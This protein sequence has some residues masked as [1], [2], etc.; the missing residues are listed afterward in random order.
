[1]SITALLSLGE[2]AIAAGAKIASVTFQGTNA[3]LGVTI[4]GSGFG[5]PPPGVPCTSCS[6]PFIQ[7]G[8]RIGC[9][10]SYN[11]V[12]WSQTTIVLSGLQANPNN[13]IVVTVTNPQN[14]TTGVLSTVT[15]SRIGLSLP[16]IG[17]VSFAGSGK[18]LQMTITGSGFGTAPLGV[19][20][21]F[22]LPFFSFIDQ[23]FD[24]SQ[25]QAG[26]SGC[27]NADS[28]AL[29]YASWSNTK[30]LIS[31]FGTK[32]GR[33]P[34]GQRN[35]TVATGDIIAIAVANSGTDGLKIGYSYTPSKIIIPFGSPLG[36]G[37]VWG[38]QLP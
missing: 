12:S 14:K 3:A 36:T 4:F 24:S 38:G 7:I 33:G 35:W 20:S 19:P 15:P 17:S 25:W 28:V 29:D 18:T 5:F 9:F 6:T 8:G 26:Y 10:D 22:I 23:P 2:I 32:Y 31:G 13:T 16:K 34:H 21:E 27:G 11:I 1:M 30:I 37:A